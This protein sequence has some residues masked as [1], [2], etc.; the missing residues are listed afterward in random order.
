MVVLRHG[1]I[2]LEWYA[3]GVTRDHNHNIFSITKS[4]VSAMCGAAVREGMIESP[5]TTLNEIFAPFPNET[6]GELSLHHLLTMQSGLPQSRG[7]TSGPSRELFDSLHAAPNRLEAIA[8]LETSGEPGQ[9]FVYGNIEP[10]L[11]L[12]AVE[13]AT[14]QSA[15]EFA[16]KRLFKPMEFENSEWKFADRSGHAPGGYGLRLRAIDLA[17]FGQLYLQK[18]KWNG[19]SLLSESWIADSSSNQTGSGY[20]YYWWLPASTERPRPFAAKGVRGQQI[21]VSPAHQLVFVVT[22]DLPPDQVRPILKELNDQL[23]GAVSDEPRLPENPDG[24]KRLIEELEAVADFSPT[25]PGVPASRRPS[26]PE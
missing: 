8:E 25:K 4:F 12:S 11:V 9:E 21:L 3:G 16:S 14:A 5:S 23:L 20:G 18:G 15:E 26:I 17:K 10:Q 7:N 6:M 1:K 24:L 19:Q 13:K 2:A 22:A